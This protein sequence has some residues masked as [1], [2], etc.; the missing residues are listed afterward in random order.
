MKFTPRKPPRTYRPLANSDLEIAHVAD[1][2]LATNE[3]VTL[4]SG[5]HAEWDILRKDWG[6]YATPSLNRR[7]VSF[8]LRSALCRNAAGAR[9]LMLVN[10][11]GLDRFRDYCTKHGLEITEWLDGEAEPC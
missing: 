1:L 3:Q 6:F 11:D 4:L 9:F 7:L 8:G 5:D 10:R 2:E